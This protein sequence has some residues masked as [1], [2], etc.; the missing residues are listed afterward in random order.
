MTGGQLVYSSDAGAVVALDPWSGRRLWGPAL[1]QPKPCAARWLAV[2]ARAWLRACFTMTGSTWHRGTAT[3]CF[4][5]DA[6]SGT[7]L[8]ERPGIEVVHLLGAFGPRL[9]FTTVLGL[10]AR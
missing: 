1:S 3:H 5:L 10:R 6:G 8:W 9:F 7:V 2:A 4:G